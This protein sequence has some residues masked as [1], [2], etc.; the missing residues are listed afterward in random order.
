LV[1]SIAELRVTNLRRIGPLALRPT[2]TIAS[3]TVERVGASAKLLPFRFG[4]FVPKVSGYGYYS[5]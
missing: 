4:I 1:S 5:G 2:A 3:C